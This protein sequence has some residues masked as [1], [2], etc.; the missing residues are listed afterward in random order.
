MIIFNEFDYFDRSCCLNTENWRIPNTLN[1]YGIVVKF[2]AP[3]YKIHHLIILTQQFTWIPMVSKMKVKQKQISI[4]CAFFVF[5]EETP[6]RIVI[7]KLNHK[8]VQFFFYFLCVSGKRYRSEK[9]CNK[10]LKKKTK[11]NPLCLHYTWILY[12]FMLMLYSQLK[13][14][15]PE[16]LFFVV[17]IKNARKNYG[18]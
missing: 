10:K 7:K 15:A 6:N 3:W 1:R 8:Y 12:E 18:M 16:L 17:C 9:K 13:W 11:T 4:L 14:W 5:K 2:F